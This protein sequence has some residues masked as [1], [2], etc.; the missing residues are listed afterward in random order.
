VL[1]DPWRV[2]AE[3][4]EHVPE[5]HILGRCM[6]FTSR[7]SVVAE[8]FQFR[9]FEECMGAEQSGRSELACRFILKA[10][11]L[12]AASSNLVIIEQKARG[13]AR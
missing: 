5:N 7:D 3:Y 12:L 1:G 6:F 8:T 9:C 13:H 4:Q 2:L 10:S 11:S